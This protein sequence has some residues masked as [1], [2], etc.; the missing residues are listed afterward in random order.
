MYYVNHQDLYNNQIYSH[1]KQLH[2]YD[3]LLVLQQFTS[4]MFGWKIKNLHKQI[5][6]LY[7]E[8][9]VVFMEIIKNIVAWCKSAGFLQTQMLLVIVQHQSMKTGLY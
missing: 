4:K 7:V 5:W 8:A 6:A 9:S 3:W 2:L 1:V